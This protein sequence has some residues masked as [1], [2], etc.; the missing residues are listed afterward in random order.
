VV[1]VPGYRSRGPGSIPVATRFSEKE[2][3]WNGVYSASWVTIEE[4]LGRKSSGSGLESRE[5]G[6]GDPLCWP[7]Q[8]SSIR[9]KLA[10]TSP[11]SGGRSVVIVR[12]RTRSTELYGGAEVKFHAFTNYEWF[13]SLYTIAHCPTYQ[14]VVCTHWIFISGDPRDSVGATVHRKHIAPGRNLTVTTHCSW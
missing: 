5:Y 2:W 4:L 10:L 6:R 9:K 7:L 1:R 14:C 8:T 12:S 11:T 13:F 3:V